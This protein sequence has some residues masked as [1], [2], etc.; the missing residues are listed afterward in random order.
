VADGMA[1]F[2]VKYVEVG[3]ESYAAVKTA[4]ADD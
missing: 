1:H 2:G 3:N 4:S